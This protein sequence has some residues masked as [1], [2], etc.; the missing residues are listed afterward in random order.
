MTEGEIILNFGTNLNNKM[1]EFGATT[2][3]LAKL[4][5]AL[6]CDAGEL[7]RSVEQ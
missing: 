2:R 1:H 6:C 3:Q 5:T 7:Y 4:C